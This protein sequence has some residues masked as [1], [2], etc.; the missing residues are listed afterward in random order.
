MRMRNRND[1]RRVT[2]HRFS[3]VISSLILF[4]VGIACSQRSAQMSSATQP[5]VVKPQ[6]DFEPLIRKLAAHDL[7]IDGRNAHESLVAAGADAFPALIFHFS[8]R[9]EASSQ[10]QQQTQNVTTVGEACFAIVQM[11]IEGR[12]PKDSRQFQ[13]LTPENTREWLAAHRGFTLEELRKAASRE[14]IAKA[15]AA[16]AANPSDKFL[17]KEVRYLKEHAQ[18]MG[19]ER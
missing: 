15:E 16:L 14:S 13:V 5:V 3:I 8:D 4:P 10:F 1:I 11:Q 2:S 18:E 9:D 12:S 19:R 6:H 17:K 7:E